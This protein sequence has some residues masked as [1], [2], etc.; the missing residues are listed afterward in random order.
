[1][2]YPNLFIPGAPKCGTTS[3]AYYLGQHPD[4]FAPLIK[5]PAFFGSDLNAARPRISLESYLDLYKEW[6]EE[7]VA[8]DASTHYF[9]AKRAAA[10]IAEAAPEARAVIM[11]RNPVEATYSMYHQLVFNG[12]EQPNSF[13]ESLDAE[14]GR[15]TNAEV[16]RFAYSQNFLYSKIFSFDENI[17]RFEFCL[18]KERVRVVLLDDLKENP[19][20]QIVNICNWLEIKV[21]PVYKFDLSKKNEAKTVRIRWL[22]TIAN[23]PPAWIGNFTKPIFSK[24]SRVGVRTFL[25][26]YNTKTSK[27]P[28][29]HA[30]TRRRLVNHYTPEI[31]KLS[32]RLDRDLSHWLSTEG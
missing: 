24:K 28:P 31:E 8:F 20:E 14:S 21:A 26:R 4:I 30:E 15:T 7:T 13:E 18:G 16:N 10:E 1:M 29:M 17:K 25:G 23:Y 19:I 3:L 9:S 11:V 6:K 2:K 5:E 32:R 12:A 27:N 22:N